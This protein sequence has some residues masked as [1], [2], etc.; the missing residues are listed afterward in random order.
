VVEPWVLTLVMEWR[1][2]GGGVDKPCV[3]TRFGARTKRALAAARDR[4]LDVFREWLRPAQED[5]HDNM[6]GLLNNDDLVCAACSL[7]NVLVGR[8]ALRNHVCIVV[9]P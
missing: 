7:T 8:G 6:E 3:R 2:G 4:G 1:G 5:S 9:C